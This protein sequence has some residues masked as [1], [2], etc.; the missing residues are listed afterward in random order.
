LLTHLF[1]TCRLAAPQ[2]CI[3]FSMFFYFSATLNGQRHELCCEYCSDM[4]KMW[5]ESSWLSILFYCE[6]CFTVR[7]FCFCN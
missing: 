4:E 3:S 1:W 5:W 6:F 7:S 2:F